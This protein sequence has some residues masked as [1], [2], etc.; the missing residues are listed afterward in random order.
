MFEMSSS[1]IFGWIGVTLLQ[2]HFSFTNRSVAAETSPDL[3]ARDAQE[4]LFDEFRLEHQVPAD[5]LVRGFERLVDLS[6]IR[7]H[8]RPFDS[9]MGRPSIDPQDPTLH[10]APGPVLLSRQIDNR[11]SEPRRPL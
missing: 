10:L 2:D 4:E 6:G 1:L 7:A 11:P 3:W 8:L 5:P 9:E